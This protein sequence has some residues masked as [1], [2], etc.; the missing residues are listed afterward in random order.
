[1]TRSLDS[2]R[3]QEAERARRRQRARKRLFLAVLPAAGVFSVCAAYV[4]LPATVAADNYDYV[5]SRPALSAAL[6]IAPT[7]LAAGLVLGLVF[8][9]LVPELLG[10]GRHYIQ[11]P[12]IGVLF[13]VLDPFVTAL[14]MPLSRFF[15][16]ASSVSGVADLS[17]RIVDVVYGTPLFALDYGVR[18]IGEGLLA[19]VGAVIVVV[20]SI[21]G[22]SGARRKWAHPLVSASVL[23][24]AAVLLLVFGPSEIFRGLVDTFAGR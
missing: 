17:N 8:G 2:L 14:L 24:L 22:F 4:T 7:S 18:G 9:W 23:S 5:V 19:G 15:T 20:V 3:Q 16:D 21:L 1:M 10:D 6:H 11:I 12:L 13:G